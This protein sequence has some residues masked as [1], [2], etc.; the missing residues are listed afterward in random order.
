MKSS[1]VTGIQEL[2]RFV[3]ATEGV[4]TIGKKVFKDPGTR[5]EAVSI[6]D[7]VGISVRRHDKTPGWNSCAPSAEQILLPLKSHNH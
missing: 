2:R 3:A 4:K 1:A 6:P 7:S 5:L